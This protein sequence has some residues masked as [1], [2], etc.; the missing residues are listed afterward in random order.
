ML[1]LAAACALVFW[2]VVR[3]EFVLWD[4]DVNVYENPHLASGSAGTLLR[5]WARPYKHL[6]I[7]VTYTVWAVLVPVARACARAGAADGLNPAVFHAANLVVH[8]LNALLVF[9][10]LRR[11]LPRPKPGE[12]PA[13]ARAACAGAALFALHPLQVECVAWVTG[14]KDLLGACLSLC[15]VLLYLRAVVPAARAPAPGRYEARM[16]LAASAAF[17]LALLAK[18][19]AAALPL[20]A[21]LVG[22]LGLTRTAREPRGA[23]APAAARVLLS[24]APWLVGW[25]LVVAVCTVLTHR[26]QEMARATYLPALW[27]RPFIAADA[28]AFY[29]YKLVLPIRLGIDYGHAPR[30]LQG[31]TWLYL[32]WLVPAALAAV[33]WAWHKRYPWALLSLAVFTAF[34]APVL[35]FVAFIFQEY[36]TVADRFVYPAMLGP[37][38]A[39][40]FAAARTRS[41][42]AAFAWAAALAALGALSFVQARTWHDNFTLFTH[43]LRVNPRSF[44]SHYNLGK[45]HEE[46]GRLADA[47]HHYSTA[48]AI[49]KDLTPAYIKLGVAKRKMGKP[50]EALAH[51]SEAVAVEPRSVDARNNYGVALAFRGE[52]TPALLHFFEALKVDPKEAR[53]HYNLGVTLEQLGKPESALAHYSQAHALEPTDADTL[54]NV[55][56]L[57]RRMGRPAEAAAHFADAVRYN[58]RHAQAHHNLGIV[59]LE[60]GRF[61]EAAR[62]FSEAFRL[63]PAFTEA[64]A[65]YERAARQAANPRARPANSAPTP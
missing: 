21:P 42:R 19:A 61:A 14:M 23:R 45:A 64:H 38:L 57:L 22:I 59:R 52:L 6:Y 58:P 28:L 62:H 31:S 46:A 37:S 7:P 34:L 30:L 9:A 18:P 4:D 5:F 43:A 2:P 48:V 44:V 56:N 15:T 65:L 51:F 3:H 63:D 39:L 8:L 29:L 32:A 41:R 33:L 40:A 49:R 50:D 10:L 11:V 36:S 53:T 16:L 47:V 25:A 60:A 12:E 13:R 54:N 20:A 26:S 55:G 35:G 27:Q 24:T 1:R 17:V